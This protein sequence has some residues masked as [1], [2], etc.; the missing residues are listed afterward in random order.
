[1]MDDFDDFP[2][3][4]QLGWLDEQPLLLASASQTRMAMLMD[5]GLPIVVAPS[6]VDEA[7]VKA[8]GEAN[9]RSAA[10]VAQELAAAK[11]VSVSQMHPGQITVGADQMLV[12]KEPSGAELWFDKPDNRGLAHKNL[13]ILSGKSHQLVTATAVCVDG[14]VQWSS[15]RSAD[16]TMRDLSDAYIRAYLDTLGDEVLWSVGGYQLE[17]LGAQLFDAVEGDF[18]TILGMDLTGLLAHLRERQALLA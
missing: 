11:A 6:D 1:M 8:D 4:P 14:A 2:M 13:S 17:G 9:G 10:D 16:L 18:F 7:P 15:T 5:A 12:L 3:P